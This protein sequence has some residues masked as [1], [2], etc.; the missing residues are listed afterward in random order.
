MEFEP[1]LLEP[2]ISVGADFEIPELIRDFLK[3][4]M[5]LELE[6]DS[7][8]KDIAALSGSLTRPVFVAE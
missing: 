6:I 2:M 1:L 3:V 4:S 5:P 8:L 7:L